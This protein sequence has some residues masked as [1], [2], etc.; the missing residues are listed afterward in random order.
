MRGD[1]LFAT[2]A[3]AIFLAVSACSVYRYQHAPVASPPP[4]PPA[5]TAP[6]TDEFR[7]QEVA[8]QLAETRGEILA[9]KASL[10]QAGKYSCCVAPSCNHC[11]LAHGE[12]DCHH[13]VS[14]SGPC[15]ECMQ[16]W[17]EGRGELPGTDAAEILAR[18]LRALDT[19]VQ[20]EPPR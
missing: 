1:K 17:I 14:E 19:T 5:E 10:E 9:I 7:A 2:G 8:A 11:L 20:E 6:V 16:G 4:S 15:G 3:G 18:K 12:C 13:Q